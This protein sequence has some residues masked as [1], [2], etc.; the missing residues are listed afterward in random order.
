MTPAYSR[1]ARSGLV[2]AYCML[3]TLLT[4]IALLVWQPAHAQL[5]VDISGTG[6]T[7]YPVAI[8][9]FAGDDEQGR[10]LAD[11]I[12]ADLTRTGQFRLINAA[13]AG[14]NVDSQVNYDDWRNRGADFLAYGSITRGPDGRYDVRYRL[15]DTIKKGQLDGV[16]FS[17]TEKELR[18]I[19]HQIADRI[20]EK[21]TGVRGVF[22]TRIAYVLKRGNTY[23]LQVADADGQNPQVAL[24]SR[25]PV[26]SPSWSPDGSKLAYVSFESGKPVVYVHT[27]ATS[28]RVPVANFKGNN[29]APAWSPDG[30]KLA[31]ALTRD[32]LSQIY[33]VSA[34]GSSNARRLTRS[35]GIDTEPVF[36]PDG[37]SII[38]TSDRSGGPQIYQTSLDGGD[39]RRL[40]FNGSYNISPRISPDGSTLLYVSRR[41]GAFRIASLDLATGNETLL[42][43][44]RDDQSPSFAPNGKQILYAAVQNGRSVLAG[45]SSDGR[46]RQT[47]SVLNGEIREP[48]WGPFT[49]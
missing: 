31:V 21:I 18:R 47:L 48:T 2:R 3:F 20:Y 25:E 9:D 23:E 5:R 49:R 24:R 19:A 35:P 42:T 12:R 34:D 7:Q 6:A 1:P 39:A 27:L 37:R 44:G 29:S 22:S 41:D 10:A 32:G 11:V 30:S 26:I 43:D 4:A 28:A 33:I 8:A 14:L 38:F 17:G 46:V 40:T 13:G 45:V 15:G 16:A 36:T